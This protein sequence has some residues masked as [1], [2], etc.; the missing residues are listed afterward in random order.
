MVRVRLRELS[1]TEWLSAGLGQRSDRVVAN[2]LMADQTD[3]SRHRR[4]LGIP[5]AGRIDY[6]ALPL[7][8]VPCRVLG[9]LVGTNP[10]NVESA[11]R[12]RG[13][14]P[15]SPAMY[16]TREGF[17]ARSHEEV[18]MDAVLHFFGLPHEH[19][20]AMPGTRFRADFY[21]TG[22]SEF[23]EVAA[24]LTDRRYAAHHHRKRRACDAAGLRVVWLSGREVRA[25]ARDYGPFTVRLGTGA[26]CAS[27]GSAAARLRRGLC[28]RCYERRQRRN[29]GRFVCR[30][31]ECGREFR[32]RR[33]ARYCSRRCAIAGRTFRYP[34]VDE[35]VERACG[36]SVKS[37]AQELGVQYATLRAYL[38]PRLSGPQRNRLKAAEQTR[39]RNSSPIPWPAVEEL[40][41]LYDRR[42]ARGIA[43]M[44]GVHP[45]TV[46]RRIQQQRARRG[47]PTPP[48]RPPARAD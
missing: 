23:V 37:V 30:C 22:S 16:L 4:R 6:S 19:E 13:I 33:R 7:G 38:K 40:E 15:R 17:P 3:V 39:K 32:D 24:M 42:G 28:R 41:R 5:A 44:L 1:A 8:Q 29:E 10:R 14:N 46:T 45:G 35:L 9:E 26:R 43:D 11:C 18:L 34:P 2:S 25:L 36:S 12:R 20:V 27:C 48:L 47:L 21:L 31:A